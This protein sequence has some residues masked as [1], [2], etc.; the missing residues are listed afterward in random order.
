M[1]PT[2]L[3]I[4]GAMIAVIAWCLGWGQGY[5]NA[6]RTITEAAI[7]VGEFRRLQGLK[8]VEHVRM[9]LRHKKFRVVAAEE[10]NLIQ[11][12]SNFKP[13]RRQR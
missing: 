1:S 4:G 10:S 13:W 9:A 12:P 11:L 6:H 3:T 5:D 2:I 8:L 7:E